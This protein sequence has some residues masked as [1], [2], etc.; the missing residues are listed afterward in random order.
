MKPQTIAAIY[1]LFWF[2][3][4][5]LVLP[6]EARIKRDVEVETVPGQADSAP[7]HFSFWRVVL[8]T[9]IVAAILFLIF[10][11]NYTYEWVT[12]HSFDRFFDP[13]PA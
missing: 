3:S 9:S 8:R 7:P 13:P 12:I 6:F 10:W 1:F 5:F 2:L 4:L 11:L